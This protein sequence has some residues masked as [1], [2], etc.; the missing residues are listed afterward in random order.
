MTVNTNK[1]IYQV[2]NESE[3]LKEDQLVVILKQRN[4]EKRI[5]EQTIELIF[6]GGRAPSI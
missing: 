2:L 6:D 3:A 4:P 1:I 5:Y